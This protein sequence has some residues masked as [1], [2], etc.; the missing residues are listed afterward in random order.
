MNF[1]WIVY[2]VS[3]VGSAAGCL[4]LF[5]LFHQ[6]YVDERYLEPQQRLTK[7]VMLAGSLFG[8]AFGILRIVFLSS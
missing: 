4:L 6:V 8:I 1:S 3:A 2:I 7:K 5:G